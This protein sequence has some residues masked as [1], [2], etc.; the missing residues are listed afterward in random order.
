M[1]TA[2]CERLTAALRFALAQPPCVLVLSGGAD[3]WSNGIH[4]NVIEAAESPADESWRN[5]NA[6]NDLTQTLIEASD[7]LIVAAMQGNAGAGGVFMAL[8]ADQVWARKGVVLNP[9]YKNMG[10]LYGS[11]Y[12][13]YLLPRRLK[14]VS[15]SDLM[16]QRLPL[17]AAQAASIGLVDAVLADS[18]LI[19]AIRYESV[20]LRWPPVPILRRCCSPSANDANTTR[21][22]SRSPAIESRNS[23]ECSATSRLRHQLSHRS[24]QLR[25]AS[26][27]FMDAPPPG[28]HRRNAPAAPASSTDGPDTDR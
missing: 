1:S 3:F 24:I 27:S 16:G 17:S 20:R 6:M 8:A 12:W 19:S 15:S 10:N 26:R 7:R 4:L 21:R 22:T 9:H 23:L 2:H 18:S 13:T 5:I 28:N 25:A 14:S 11:E